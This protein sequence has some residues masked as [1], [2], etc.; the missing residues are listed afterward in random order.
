MATQNQI[1]NINMSRVL[2]FLWI[3]RGCSRARMCRDLGLN[4]ST[5]TKNVQILM[6]RGIAEEIKE[7]NSSPL[8]GRRPVSLGVR[9]DFCYILGMEIQTEFYHAVISNARGQIVFTRSNRLQKPDSSLLDHFLNALEEL[10]PSMEEYKVSGIALGLPGVIDSNKGI[11]CYSMAFGIQDPL[12]FARS[13]EEA[14]GYPVFIENDANCCCWGDLAGQ[15][16]SRVENSLFLLSEFR[17]VDVYSPGLQSLALGIGLVLGGQVHSGKDYS[18]GE[19]TS[20]LKERNGA[21]Q[22]STEPEELG[23]LRNNPEVVIRIVHEIS[24]NISSLVN[25]L[26]LS[27]VVV[28]GVLCEFKTMVGEQ[29]RVCINESWPYANPVECQIEFS[30]LGESMVAYGATGYFLEQLFGLPELEDRKD[31]GWQFILS[32]PLLPDKNKL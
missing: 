6:D 21:G 2:R 26:N 13:A 32:H 30:E 16:A 31:R 17:D 12:S 29:L 20:V 19:F 7:G 18:A 25:V 23:D 3:N 22:F 4:K 14:S 9:Q 8:G 15:K 1:N 5:I 27:R 11:I 24:R 10:K 28:G